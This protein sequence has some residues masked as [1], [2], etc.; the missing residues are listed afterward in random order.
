MD[1]TSLVD[2]AG[3]GATLVLYLLVALSALQLAL[4]VERAIVFVRTR[5]PSN[6]RERV[7]GALGRDGAPGVAL[8]IGSS[9]A[10]EAR[11][12]VVGAA[13]ADRGPAATTELMTSALTDEKL[14]LERGLA[15]L[16]TLGN[17]APFIGL[18][19]TVLGIIHTVA[20]M[21]SAGTS[22][23]SREVMGGISEA[24]VATAVGLMV[25]LP[26]VAAYNA[27]QRVLKTRALAAQ[28]L[29]GELVASLS[30][31]APSSSMSMRKVA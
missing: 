28:S 8:A 2:L 3:T 16:G 18:F 12:L 25:A 20:G 13:S 24:L 26:A 15:F 1:M 19:G 7:R 6:L 11:V 23:A 22:Q 4:I 5:A 17:N 27:F 30:A 9:P 14:K 29:G 31:K 21:S 10:L